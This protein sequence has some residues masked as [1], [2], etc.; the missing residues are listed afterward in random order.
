MEFFTQI[1]KDYGL[2]AGLVAYVLWENNR[3]EQRYIGIIDR[4]A[5]SFAEMKRDIEEIK[6]IIKKGANKP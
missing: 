5:N 1:V 6:N 2:F 3:R 4:L